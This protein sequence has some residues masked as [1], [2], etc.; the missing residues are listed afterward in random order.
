MKLLIENWRKHLNEVYKI[1]GVDP[2]SREAY[3]PGET[4]LADLKKRPEYWSGEKKTVDIPADYDEEEPKKSETLLG[5]LEQALKV[6]E[7]AEYES[8][9]ERWKSYAADIQ[10]LVDKHKKP[11]P[12]TPVTGMDPSNYSQMGDAGPTE[13]YEE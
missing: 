9:E 7:E 1:S 5:D 10:K 13:Y 6:W 4:S 3:T 11:A 8:D 2:R 12:I